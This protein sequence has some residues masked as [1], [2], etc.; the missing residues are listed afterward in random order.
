MWATLT[1]IEPEVMALWEL[2]YDAW[3]WMTFYV[4]DRLAICDCGCWHLSLTLLFDCSFKFSNVQFLFNECKPQ[5]KD[6]INTTHTP[7]REFKTNITHIP[8]QTQAHTH[9]PQ[10]SAYADMQAYECNKFARWVIKS[11]RQPR[12]L[13]HAFIDWNKKFLFKTFRIKHYAIF[14]PNWNAK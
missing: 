5:R 13:F 1:G 9:T 2:S 4:Y 14:A 8:R 11:R 12:V 3:S 7:W 10:R 6:E